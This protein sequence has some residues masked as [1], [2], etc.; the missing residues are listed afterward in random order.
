MNDKVSTL[1]KPV[2]KLKGFQKVFLKSG[3]KKTLTFELDET[4]FSNYNVA[5][6]AWEIESGE[7]VI[8][9]GNHSRNLKLSKQINL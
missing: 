4:A 8:S 5:K 1:E 9:A 7:F 6:K 2:H 3:E